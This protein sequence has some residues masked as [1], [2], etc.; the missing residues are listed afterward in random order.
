MQKGNLILSKLMKDSDTHISDD[1][2]CW[3]SWQFYSMSN[4]FLNPSPHWDSYLA[5]D[6]LARVVFQLLHVVG[7]QNG[8]KQKKAAIFLLGKLQNLKIFKKASV[9]LVSMDQ[10]KVTKVRPWRPWL[11][12][13]CFRGQREAR[14]I[15]YPIKMAF[16]VV[17][18]YCS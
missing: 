17:F 11:Q 13:P 9:S 15:A 3:F 10:C 5:L 16:L 2:S 12:L 4:H 7:K 6:T 1:Q 18:F 14:Q 8:G